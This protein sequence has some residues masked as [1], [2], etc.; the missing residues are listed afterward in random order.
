MLKTSMNLAIKDC[1][2]S[3]VL[4][5]ALLP[6]L[7]SY[8]LWG[9]LFVA[10]WEELLVYF[11]DLLSISV[12]QDS[13]FY[14]AKTLLDWV[15]SGALFVVLFLF[16]WGFAFGTN[17]LICAVISPFV[18]DYVA[19]KHFNLEDISLL[20]DSAPSLSYAVK[21]KGVV[22]G[23]AH[24]LGYS[25][26]VLLQT[27]KFIGLYF[28]WLIVLLP[29]YFIPFIGVVIFMLPS[30]WLFYQQMRWDIA[31][32]VWNN[33]NSIKVALAPYKKEIFTTMGVLYLLG[34]LPIIGFFIP[35]FSYVILTHLFLRIKLQIL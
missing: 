10:Y 17:L 4:L 7:C 28:L 16:F 8:L 14:W 5:I 3:Y 33:K 9:G 22:L 35:I 25:V 26:K 32:I 23:S 13:W 6:V 2:S 20:P 11:K 30:F 34:L 15:V 24:W 27:L 1:F 18:V 31:S 12:A 29:C 19:K 21:N